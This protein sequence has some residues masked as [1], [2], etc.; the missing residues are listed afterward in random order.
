MLKR[1]TQGPTG[2][3]L[4]GSSSGIAGSRCRVPSP[5][6]KRASG[7]PQ[8]EG[9][10]GDV[11]ETGVRQLVCKKAATEPSARTRAQ[12]SKQS[13]AIRRQEK[14]GKPAKGHGPGDGSNALQ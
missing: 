3:Q 7:D 8:A 14:R 9:R 10:A 2:Q 4:E 12:A 13:T 11:G 5:Q 1:A 6:P